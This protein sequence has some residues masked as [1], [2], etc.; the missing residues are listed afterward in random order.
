[1]QSDEYMELHNDSVCVFSSRRKSELVVLVHCFSA[2]DLDVGECLLLQKVEKTLSRKEM[3][4]GNTERRHRLA[5]S[6]QT[7]GTEAV[8]VILMWSLF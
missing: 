7:K 2:N 3:S 1:M 5:G 4:T 6:Y 8:A